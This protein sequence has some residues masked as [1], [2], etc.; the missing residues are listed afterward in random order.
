MVEDVEELSSKTKADLF[1]D[2]KLSLQRYVE[3]R[4]S[5]ASQHVAPEIALLP[6]WHRSKRQS[7][8]NL[9]AGILIAVDLQRNAWVHIRT[10]SER[11]ASSKEGCTNNVNRRRRPGKDET[12]QRPAGQH[13]V[14]NFVQSWRWQIVC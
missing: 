1:G 9:P 12:V 2:V 7:I 4:S 14:D 11:R 6:D 3:L 10:R 5:E 8:Q 13:C